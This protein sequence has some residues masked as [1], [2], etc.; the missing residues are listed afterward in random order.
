MPFKQFQYLK[1]VMVCR[2]INKAAQN[3]YISPQALRSAIG[4]MED[5]L[6][7]KIF[8]RSKHGVTLTPEG[9]E[10]EAD[11]DEIIRISERWDSIRNAHNC[12]SGVVR[13]GTSTSV[14]T[15]IFPDVMTECREKYPQ[16]LLL[17]YEARD[18]A[19]LSLLT[20]KRMIGV[21]GAV[22]T[23]EVEGHYTQFAR[24]NDYMLEVLRQD[25]F[26]VYLNS[27]N[28][29]ASKETLT[30][31]DLSGLTPAFFPNE[32]KRMV[33]GSIFDHFSSATPFLLMHQESIFALVAERPDVACIFPAIAGARDHS[34]LSG[35]VR[36]RTIAD[37]P[38]PAMACMLYPMPRSLSSGEKAVMDMIREKL[39]DPAEMEEISL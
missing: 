24:E 17:Q 28:P 23:S 36:A 12:V 13:L 1:E 32:N 26:Y 33:Y 11:V 25:Q 30:L 38:M 4:S 8:E 37:Y 29:L 22:P 14:C 27:R 18:D 35:A 6:G 19:L 21:M 5:K 15:A 2:S 16:L 20:Q 39:K 9:E 31:S 3:L 7:F 34:V 10:I